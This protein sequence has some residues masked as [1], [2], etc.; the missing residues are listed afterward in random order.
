M[1]APIDFLAIVSRSDFP[2]GHGPA[3]DCFGLQKLRDRRRDLN[4]AILELNSRPTELLIDDDH[5]TIAQEGRPA[6]DLTTV[7][8][9]LYLPVCLEVEETNLSPPRRDDPYP[10]F[11]AQ[12]WRPITEFI[13]WILSTGGYCL[14]APEK[15]RRANNKLIQ[16]SAF[17]RSEIAVPKACVA[18]GYPDRSPLA[19]FHSLIAKNVSESGWKAPTVFSPAR[20]VE[21][22]DELE[23]YPIIYQQPVLSSC[24][25]RCYIMGERVHFVELERRSDIVDVRTQEGGKPHATLVAGRPEWAAMLVAGARHLGLD[26]AVA[27]AIPNGEHLSILEINANGVWWFLP[28]AVGAELER[29]FH[30][31]LERF[32]DSRRGTARFSA[33]RPALPPSCRR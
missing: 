33:R 26:Y 21:P 7:G 1:I 31:F 16:F 29:Y 24:E 6:V 23:N 17:A 18:T 10:L 8:S 11:T 15:V 28:A 12:Q 5:I 32:I 27:D 30:Q 4:I 20:W 19:H 25:L 3:G 22:G 9:A 14:N 2:T 13:E